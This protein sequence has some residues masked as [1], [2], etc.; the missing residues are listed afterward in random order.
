MPNSAPYHAI[1]DANRRKILDLLRSHGSLRAGEIVTQLP[2]IS[3]PAVSKH[4]RILREAK[5]VC[6]V[7]DGRERAYSLNPE[8]LRQM[9]EWLLHYEPL[10]DSRLDTLKQ[11]VEQEA[12]AQGARP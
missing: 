8:T 6:A 3:Q 11:L 10:W 5:L 2:H 12:Q 7:A 1:A 4:L 9:A